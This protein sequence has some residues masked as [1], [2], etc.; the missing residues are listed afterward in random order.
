[1]S[2]EGTYTPDAEIIE[3]KYNN[4]INELEEVDGS[5]HPVIDIADKYYA[6]KPEEVD[7]YLY[8]IA[9]NILSDMS[10][11]SHLQKCLYGIEELAE[12]NGSCIF[13][14]PLK[15]MLKH[16]NNLLL[17]MIVEV[18]S[19]IN[20]LTKNTS[21]ISYLFHNGKRCFIIT[22]TKY[23]IPIIEAHMENPCNKKDF[24]KTA[25]KLIKIHYD[26]LERLENQLAAKIGNEDKHK[27]IVECLSFN[28]ER[29]DSGYSMPEWRDNLDAFYKVRDE[30]I[31]KKK[32]EEY[33]RQIK[34]KQTKEQL[35]EEQKKLQHE[36]QLLQ[37]RSEELKKLIA[38]KEN[39]LQEI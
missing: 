17:Y 28:S 16:S 18:K 9:N 4:I 39:E 6:S 33:V 24:G 7:Y 23:C 35:E 20:T 31:Q 1:M 5:I 10:L 21:N 3:R 36:Y 8:D 11:M 15:L 14:E 34:I 38:D 37:Q 32:D 29:A 12:F 27:W 30:Q 2:E 19:V 22:E 26:L 13:Y 25:N